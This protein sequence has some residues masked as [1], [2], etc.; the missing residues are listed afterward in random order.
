MHKS[1]L[2]VAVLA[3]AGCGASI[4]Q[5]K[6]PDTLAQQ[7]KM[8]LETEGEFWGLGR[9]GTFTLSNQYSGSYDR[10]AS[11]ISIL[12]DL[13]KSDKGAMAAEVVNNVTGERWKLACHGRDTSVNVGVLSLGGDN[14]YGCTIFQ[15]EKSVGTFELKK[16]GGVLDFGPAGKVEGSVKLGDTNY[17]IASVH[18]AEGSV[19]SLEQPLG[20]YVYTNKQ[21]VAAIQVNGVISLQHLPLKSQQERD[22]LAVTTVASALSWRQ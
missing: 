15:N 4:G 2:L 1:I 19:I 18:K 6:V 13:V 3:L 14:P 21:E 9:K 7:E 22:L 5:I 17:T 8:I 10:E 16:S 20:Y 11:G 12:G